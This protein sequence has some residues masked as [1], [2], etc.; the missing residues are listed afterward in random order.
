MFLTGI[1]DTLRAV[2]LGNHHKRC[3]M[4]L[5][6]IHIGIHTVGSGRS[7]RTARIAFRCLGRTGIE[8]GIV[9]EI[10]WHFFTGIQTSLQLGMSDVTGNDNRSFQV[11]TGRD[12]IL[13]Q[14]CT[15]SV[16]TFVEVDF[17]AFRTFTR[18]AKLFGN[19]L[20]RVGSLP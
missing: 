7:H 1:G 3:T 19:Q 14:F 15:N 5:E 20:C 12:R 13:G 4:I 2:T 8:H 16:N 17:Y 9:F 18:I 6:L 11:D 10:L